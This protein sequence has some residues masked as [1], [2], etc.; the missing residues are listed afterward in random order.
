MDE[1]ANQTFDEILLG[2]TAS[3]T[4][5]VIWDKVRLFGVAILTAVELL[6]PRIDRASER[7]S[8]R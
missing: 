6:N 7:R 5:T 3:L 8:A 1:S 2:V 4:P